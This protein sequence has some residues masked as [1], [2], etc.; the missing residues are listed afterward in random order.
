MEQRR[1]DM[2]GIGGWW[3]VK[4]KVD[5]GVKGYRNKVSKWEGVLFVG[6][7]VC[8]DGGGVDIGVRWFLFE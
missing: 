8:W 1:W 7:V 3:W 2:L 5:W 4:R 6:L